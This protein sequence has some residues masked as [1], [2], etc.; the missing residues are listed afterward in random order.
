MKWFMFIDKYNESVIA[1]AKDV[2]SAIKGIKECENMAN[3]EDF[4]FYMETSALEGIDE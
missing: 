4:D 2:E 3:V 1:E